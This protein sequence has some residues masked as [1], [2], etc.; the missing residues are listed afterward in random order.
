MTWKQTLETLA[1]VH[2]TLEPANAHSPVECPG[3][4]SQ[5]VSGQY[6]SRSYT[7]GSS[8]NLCYMQ[9]LLTQKEIKGAVKWKDLKVT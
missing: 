9:Q 5:M 3:V 8:R 6:E 1:C 2:F 4:S 7:R